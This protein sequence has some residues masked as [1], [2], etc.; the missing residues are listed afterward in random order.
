MA[1]LGGATALGMD[2]RIGSLLPGKEADMTAIDLSALDTAPVYDPLSHLINVA[3]REHVT[4]VWVAGQRV[5]HERRLAT[6]DEAALV[7]H[8][9]AW[10]ERLR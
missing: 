1:T 6:V 10:Q 5:V 8:A 2:G 4:D 3:G 9:R 7:T